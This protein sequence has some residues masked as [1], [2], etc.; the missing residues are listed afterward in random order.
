MARLQRGPFLCRQPSATSIHPETLFFALSA[1]VASA[2]PKRY[3]DGGWRRAAVCSR[4]RKGSCHGNRHESSPVSPYHRRCR[5]FSHS[6][7]Q[8][9]GL[10]FSR[11]RK[12]QRRP[13]RRGR[14]RRLVYQN[15]AAHI[16]CRCN[17]RCQR[18]PGRPTI[19]ND[20]GR[21]T[22]PR[23]PQDVRR[24]GQGHRRRHRR[25]SRQH[26]RCHHRRRYPPR[27]GRPHRK[28]AD[29]RRLRSPYTPRPCPPAQGRHADG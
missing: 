10:R 17:V 28:T 18:P 14:P 16:Q 1:A 26:P 9:L 21:Q 22:V 11:Q 8:P 4:Q 24:N 19:R 29:P 25:H 27:Q 12:S 6:Q 15:H 13:R 23:F 7:Q 20:P 5:G 2:R 3:H